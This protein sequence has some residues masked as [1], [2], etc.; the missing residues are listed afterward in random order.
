M[1]R[2]VTKWSTKLMLSKIRRKPSACRT[3]AAV[4]IS[5]PPA[6]TEAYRRRSR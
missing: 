3:T 5:L 1:S 2:G 6:I 4:E